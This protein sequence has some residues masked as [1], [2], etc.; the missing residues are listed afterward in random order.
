MGDTEPASHD[1]FTLT[2]EVRLSHLQPCF[3]ARDPPHARMGLFPLAMYKE[4]PTAAIPEARLRYD[5]TM[6]RFDTT[7]WASALDRMWLRLA[8]FRL[9]RNS[10]RWSEDR[11]PHLACTPLSS[12]LLVIHKESDS[13]FVQPCLYRRGRPRVHKVSFKLRELVVRYQSAS[14]ASS[15][16]TTVDRIR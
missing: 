10:D 9:G 11:C 16:S 7:T 4:E 12:A 2:V 6:E 8:F 15:G 14:H 5:D 3:A 13:I 1:G